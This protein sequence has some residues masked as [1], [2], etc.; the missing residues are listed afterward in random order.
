MLY[1]F[2]SITKLIKIDNFSKE[3]CII[4]NYKKIK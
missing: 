2:Y 1:I 3:H 4:I